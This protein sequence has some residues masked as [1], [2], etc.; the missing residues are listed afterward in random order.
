[1]QQLVLDGRALR[2]I[3]GEDLPGDRPVALY[4]PESVL[5]LAQAGGQDQR[6]AG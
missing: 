6:C 1:M 2:G 5:V 3:H 4:A